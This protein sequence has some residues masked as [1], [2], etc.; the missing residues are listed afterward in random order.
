MGLHRLGRQSEEVSNLRLVPIETVDKPNHGALS[1]AQRF[2]RI[3]Q[4]RFDPRT[5]DPHDVGPHMW[6]VS[7]LP[8]S[9]S[10]HSIQIASWIAHR[11]HTFPMLP[12]NSYVI[13][14]FPLYSLKGKG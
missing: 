1:V 3:G 10:R 4:T 14:I 11:T 13:S 9:G 12:P 8:P 2:Q 5:L 6:S 7:H